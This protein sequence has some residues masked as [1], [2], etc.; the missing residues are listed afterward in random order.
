M[1]DQYEII[2][3]IGEGGAGVVY[4]A[5]QLASERIVA[6]KMLPDT[7]VVDERSLQRFKREAKTTS[8]LD[9]PNIV[10]IF[11][12]GI[13]EDSRP[14]F[15]M[16]YLNGKTLAEVLK[17]EGTPSLERLRNIFLELMSALE[18]A[19]SKGVVH[20]DIKPGNV[21]LCSTDNSETAKLL[22]FGIARRDDSEDERKLTKTGTLVGSPSYMSPEQCK[23]QELDF[24]SD[25]YSLG[26]VMYE[27]LCGKAPFVGENSVNVLMMHLNDAVPPLESVRSDL[28]LPPRLPS[29]IYN[30]LE[31]DPSRRPQNMTEVLKRT[32]E[33]FEDEPVLLKSSVKRTPR[34]PLVVLLPL[35]ILL[36]IACGYAAV[37]SRNISAQ[38]DIET[39]YITA[40]S[41]LKT[42][43]TKRLEKHFGEAYNCYE[44]AISKLDKI[45][46]SNPEP[47]MLI[48]AKTLRRK[49]LLEMV[50]SY[51]SI[52]FNR[53]VLLNLWSEVL[54]ATKEELGPN[55]LD[56]A[57][58]EYDLA[59]AMSEDVENF[60]GKKIDEVKILLT[61]SITSVQPHLEPSPLDTDASATK[62]E[63]ARSVFALSTNLLSR[64]LQLQGRYK[65]ST[66]RAGQISKLDSNGGYTNQTLVAKARIVQN[67]RSL[68]DRENELKC[69]DETFRFAKNSEISYRDKVAA[70]YSLFDFYIKARDEQSANCV[71]NVM[72]DLS[73]EGASQSSPAAFA[74]VLCCR[75]KLLQL[76]GD[77]DKTLLEANKAY[78]ILGTIS[79]GDAPIDVWRILSSIYDSLGASTEKQNCVTAIHNLQQ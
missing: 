75:A 26:C 45:I 20:R 72:N 57:E 1:L 50:R 55:S 66:E 74:R 40:K 30:C 22:D 39:L 47:S 32:R 6:I 62:A 10:K 58:L 28:N 65:D 16:E 76:K 8:A 46:Q 42:A 36:C 56:A 59:Y 70:L 60:H 38:K 9:H 19:H 61:H 4:E 67:Y 73:S 78:S 64:I 17:S 48:S 51:A 43:Q 23:G 79:G 2:R 29:V 71:L 49:N 15:V 63:K 24:R 12:F 54:A 69:R 13:S 11:S 41:E 52:H 35:G 31:K 37:V 77:R 3:T 27:C 68:G 5:L 53:P 34:L 18:Y 25:I 14:Y 21:M 33:A 44:K 7:D